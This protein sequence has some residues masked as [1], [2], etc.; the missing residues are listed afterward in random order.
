MTAEL[1]RFLS[2]GNR[3]TILELD[4]DEPAESLTMVW[5]LVFGC[6]PD[7]SPAGDATTGFHVELNERQRGLIVSRTANNDAT[8]AAARLIAA[9]HELS[10]IRRLARPPYGTRAAPPVDGFDWTRGLEPRPFDPAAVSVWPAEPERPVL[11]RIVLEHTHEP[12]RFVHRARRSNNVEWC[13]P[14]ESLEDAL[15]FASIQNAQAWL[16][17]HATNEPQPLTM[18]YRAAAAA[19]LDQAAAHQQQGPVRALAGWIEHE[20]RGPH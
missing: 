3:W 6:E 20:G 10:E 2:G 11:D 14:A 8:Q 5:R 17:K 13:L 7:F 1:V 19:Q 18:R 12:G 16:A 4:D 15:S 9:K